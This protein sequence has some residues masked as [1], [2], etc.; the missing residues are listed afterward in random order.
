MQG[1][2]Q[3]FA[4]RVYARIKLLGHPISIIGLAALLAGAVRWL[5][6]R[7]YDTSVQALLAMGLALL[8]LFI[9]AR[10]DEVKAALAG[11][12]ARYGSNALLMSAAFLGILVLV[13]VVL[14]RH[15]YRYDSTASKEHTL[16]P[17]TIQVL[18]GLAEPV[19]VLGFFAPGDPRSQDAK[20]MLEEYRRHSDKF[21]YEFIDPDQQPSLAR[22]YEVTSY[23][24]LLFIRGDKRQQ[25]FG[26]DEQTLTSTLLKVSRNVQKT[27]YFI[28]GHNERDP[29]GTEDTGYAGAKQILE[30]ENYQVTTLNL[31]TAGEPLSA[32]IPISSVVVL[33]SPQAPLLDKEVEALL[34]WIQAGGKAM[35]LA[36]PG[37]PK[38]LGGRLDTLGLVFQDDLAIDPN[39]SFFGDVATLVVAQ[40]PFGQITDDM[41]GLITIFPGARSIRA[42]ENAPGT[43]AIEPLITSGPDSW[44][45]TDFQTRDVRFDPDKDNKGP[46]NLAYTYLDS[47][48]KARMVIFGDADFAAN[49]G[50]SLGGQVGNADLFVNSI[51][52]LAEE[53]ELISIRPKPPEQRTVVLNAPRQ[54]TIFYSSVVLLPLLVLGAGV[55]VWWRRR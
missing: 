39:S 18:E 34:G 9:L 42:L 37:L 1:R 5:I 41:G 47:N 11:R 46:L 26:V 48:T 4:N 24:T 12:T 55:F 40:Y 21:S 36:D 6:Y 14:A 13:N 32:T 43:A 10:P 49:N 50:L 27:I 44:G 38:P 22:M 29:S 17:Q 2:L 45:E 3:S 20:D 54:R 28:T 52:W 33:A 15:S 19:Q 35:I 7:Q 8:G 25:T 53:E 23:G 51:N 31:A 30:K 16:S